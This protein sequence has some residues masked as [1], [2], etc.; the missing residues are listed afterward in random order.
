MH[1]AFVELLA[2]DPAAAAEVAVAGERELR[3]A[4]EHGWRSSVAGFAAEAFYELGRDDDAW[5]YTEIAE[6]A[7]APDD[8]VTQ[9]QIRYLRAL[10]LARR[11]E[12]VEAARHAREGTQLVD[13][14]DMAH[15]A[16]NAWISSGTVAR[17]AG[18]E[19]E[20]TRAFAHAAELYERKGDVVGLRRVRALQT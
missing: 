16:A 18:R 12:L 15:L 6:E 11:G 20:A 19:D 2:G 8:I 14:T 10:L 7:A 9:V 13:G 17:A 1:E 5:R 4:G 3:A